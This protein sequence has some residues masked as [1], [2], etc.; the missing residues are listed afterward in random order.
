PADTHRAPWGHG[1]AP[2]PR[3]PL[4]PAAPRSARVTRGLPA[5][6][7]RRLSPSP[8]LR[9]P[10]SV[11]VMRSH[12]LHVPPPGHTTPEFLHILCPPARRRSGELVGDAPRPLYERRGRRDSGSRR[13]GDRLEIDVLFWQDLS[14]EI[15]CKP[16][17]H[18]NSKGGNGLGA[19]PI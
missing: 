10:C 15:T 4:P 11:P 18:R 2:V 1:G 17:G 12:Y 3:R 9:L 8:L 7:P 5:Q 14:R 6:P 19:K 16:D 13:A